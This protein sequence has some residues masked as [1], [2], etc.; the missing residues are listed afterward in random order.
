MINSYLVLTGKVTHED[1]LE[2]EDEVQLIFN[3]SIAVVP[4][5]DGVYDYV[6]QYF[7]IREEYD[8]CAELY[9]AKCKA[10]NS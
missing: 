4:L 7:E 10:K 3:P 9:W 5:E 8:K 6:R 2:Y 1:L